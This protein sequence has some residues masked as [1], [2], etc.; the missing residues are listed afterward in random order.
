MTVAEQL[1]AWAWS[2]DDPPAAACSAAARCLLDGIGTALAAQRLGAAGPAVAVATALGGPHEATILGTRTMVSAPAAALANGALVHALD[3]DDTHT[4]ALVHATA[5]VLPAALAVGEQVD[6]SGAEVLTAAI[7]GYE[8]VARLGAAV[9]HGFHSRGFH[10]TSVCGVFAAALVSARLLGLDQQQAVA[11]LG[12]AGS[13]ASGSL[14]FLSTGAST[15]QLHPGWAGR[16]GVVA[17]RLAAAGA[18]G[19]ASII[20][21]EYGL[22]R[23]YAGAAVDSDAVVGGLGE[24]W[25]VTAVTIK[26]YPACQLS[27]ATLDALAAVRDDV[28]AEVAWIEV[29]LPPDSIPIVA[30]PAATK[31]RPR[32]P[33]EAKF[34]VQW[35]AALLLADG[36]VGVD[37]FGDD[38]LARADLATLAERVTVREAAYDGPPAE[39]PG[40]VVVALADGRRL[41]GHVDRSRGTPGAPLGDTEVRDKFAANCG[42]AAPAVGELAE[43]VLALHE[44]AAVRRLVPAAAAAIREVEV[45]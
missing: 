37:A 11:A 23:L 5:A 30:E 27:H 7:A 20:E 24:R 31:V 45:A 35:C 43:Q 26:P 38:Q 21:G 15:K 41:Q 2:L 32:T 9:R 40:D 22:Y 18:S 36:A 39:A 10:A 29:S 14:E 13:Q 19:P 12:I 8:V 42:T 1:V 33:Y 16:A 3:Y 4:G 25:E 28:T 34:S 6:A 44:V 17:A